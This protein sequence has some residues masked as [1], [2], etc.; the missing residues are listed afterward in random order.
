MHVHAH[1]HVHKRHTCMLLKCTQITVKYSNSTIRYARGLRHIFVAFSK[2]AA[3]RPLYCTSVRFFLPSDVMTVRFSASLRRSARLMHG[4]ILA[5]SVSLMRYSRTRSNI[6]TSRWRLSCRSETIDWQPCVTIFHVGSYAFDLLNTPLNS[7][8]GYN[9][10]ETGTLWESRP[11]SSTV[12]S[13]NIWSNMCYSLP[14]SNNTR[15]THA[16]QWRPWAHFS[17]YCQTMTH[18]AEV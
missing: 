5:A 10:S 9:H 6:V 1:V 4:R 8:F 13:H 18:A 7:C 16:K 3:T 17:R 15:W 11:K 12:I 2:H 14:S